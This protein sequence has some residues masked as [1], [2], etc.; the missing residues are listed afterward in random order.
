MDGNPIIDTKQWDAWQAQWP[1]AKKYCIFLSLGGLDHGTRQAFAGATA[2]TPEF[3][4]K[5]GRFFS[6]LGEA[7]EIAGD[8]PE[9]NRHSRPRRAPRRGG[10]RGDRRVGEGDSQGSAGDRPLQ[11]S[12]ST[13]T[14]Q[15][16]PAE[17]FELFDILCPNRPMW[18]SHQKAFDA[19]YGKQAEAGK[20][21]QLYSCSGPARLLDPYSYYRLQAWQCWKIG[22]T[23]TF[24]WALGDNQ[25]E[26]SW[27]EYLVG[28]GPYTTDFHRRRKRSRPACRW[29]RFVRVLKISR[30]C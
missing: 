3:D 6:R 11:R 24:F 19:F 28:S 9:P 22:G 12:G 7:L 17:L 18:L 27:N 26:S 25:R 1:N 10:R 15:A 14:R 29:R 4:E 13:R 23:G 16:A 8:R 21:L 30:R 20:T 2:G 5:V